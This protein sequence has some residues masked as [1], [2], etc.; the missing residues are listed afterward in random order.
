MFHL[1]HPSL[2]THRSVFCSQVLSVGI[3]EEAKKKIGVLIGL[4]RNIS[5]VVHRA[6]KWRRAQ[7]CWR[8]DGMSL[9]ETLPLKEFLPGRPEGPDKQIA[10]THIS[11]YCAPGAAWVYMYTLVLPQWFPSPLAPLLPLLF[12]FTL[13]AHGNLI[14]IRNVFNKKKKKA[15]TSLP[16]LPLRIICWEWS[17][18]VFRQRGDADR[19]EGRGCKGRTFPSGYTTPF[20]FDDIFIRG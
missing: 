10:P 5:T 14:N 15:A 13:G 8:W 7:T 16:Q 11:T 6:R 17:P 3:H 9:P 12:T 20:S 18:H 1:P 19:P 4:C 2:H